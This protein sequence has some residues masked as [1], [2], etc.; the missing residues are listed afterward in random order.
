MR[1][2]FGGPDARRD[3]VKAITIEQRWRQV[4]RLAI[5]GSAPTLRHTHESGLVI[6]LRRVLAGRRQHGCLAENMFSK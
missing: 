2:C 5:F 4:G 3:F 1:K 6:L